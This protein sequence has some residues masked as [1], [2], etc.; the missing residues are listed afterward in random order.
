MADKGARVIVITKKAKGHA[1]HGGAWKVA[2]ADFVTA[3]MALFM[4]LWL[5][6]QTDQVTK[7]K[8]SEYFRTGMF[9]GAPSVMMGGSGIQD[10]GF[11]DANAGVLQ[12]EAK[13]LQSGAD[14][15]TEA[16]EGAKKTNSELSGLIKQVDIQVT[17]Q[18]LMIQILDGGDDLLFDLSSAE[19]K[20]KLKS[21]LSLIAP[22][23][24]KLKN[25]VQVHGHTDARPFP[26]GVVRS[27]WDLSYERANNARRELE[28]H[29][30]Q[31]GQV[32]GVFAHGSSTPYMKDDPFSSK[33]RRLTIMAL[34][35]T[36]VDSKT[37][38]PSAR[39]ANG[40]LQGSRPIKIRLN[41][42]KDEN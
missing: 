40:N 36:A 26:P 25:Q 42:P 7:Q 38:A 17:E 34:R 23:L 22:V 4:V 31:P 41:K 10:N 2:Y 33:N 27:N 5:L 13:T 12:F 24:G 8:L 6:S 19:L 32:V 21:L 29:G 11:L 14:A 18:G 28:A 1:H 15:I 35:R 30:L 9:Q 20:P 16:L 39:S 37:R 3:M